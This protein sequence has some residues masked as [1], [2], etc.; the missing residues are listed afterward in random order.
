M[1]YFLRKKKIW[2]NFSKSL[3]G[4]DSLNQPSQGHRSVLPNAEILFNDKRTDAL[5]KLHIYL[6]PS[7]CTQL[8]NPSKRYLTGLTLNKS[9][10]GSYES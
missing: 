7:P 10:P 3:F 1:M 9:P 6:L 4:F 5:N 2:L 8:K